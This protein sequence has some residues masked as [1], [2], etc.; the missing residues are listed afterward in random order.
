MAILSMDKDIFV[1]QT[2][3]EEKQI[4]N[5]AKFEWNSKLKRW[6]TKDLEKVKTLL[7]NENVKFTK[8]TIDYIKN[9]EIKKDQNYIKSLN[10]FSDLF[11]PVPEGLFYLQFQKAGIEYMLDK[12]YVLLADEMGL[13]KTIQSLGY[14]NCINKK[15]KILIICPLSLKENWLNEYNKWIINKN[16]FET[17]IINYDMLNKKFDELNKNWDL[18]ICDEAHYIK[19]ENA[20]R[21]KCVINL[22]EKSEKLI[23]LTGTPI[24]NRIQ[25]LFN[26]L[27]VLKHPLSDNWYKFAVK[28][29]GYTKNENGY[30]EFDESLVTDK[31]LE[32]LQ[33]T[34]RQT[35]MV[36]RM[37]SEVLAELPDKRRQL[38]KIEPDATIRKFIKEETELLKTYNVDKEELEKKMDLEYQKDINGMV[39]DYDTIPITIMSKIKKETGLLKVDY[40]IKVL[41]EMLVNEIKIVVFAWHTE[42]IERIYNEFK[43][44]SVVLTGKTPI[45][46]R[47]K[48]VEIFQNDKNCLLFLG[49]I[50]AA[51]VGI[52]LTASSN[53]VFVEFDWTP[54]ALQ[55]AEDRLHRIGQKDSVNIYHFVID[56]LID[57][58]ILQT[59]L[60]KQETI[61]KVLN[62]KKNEYIKNQIDFTKTKI[63]EIKNEKEIMIQ[64]VLVAKYSEKQ[65]KNMCD[66]I[67]YMEE[68]NFFSV[69]DKG[70]MSSFAYQI[71]QKRLLSEKQLTI[72]YQILL[73]SKNC[74]PEEIFNKIFV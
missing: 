26:I 37:K 73:K 62:D 10:K 47:Q 18:M 23:L 42:V 70:I 64:D 65:I 35:I 71:K 41:K 11:I 25:E 22:S 27:K 8:D 39:F 55:Q 43:D 50:Q 52:T 63:V 57:A 2:V 46:E 3:Y 7:K 56:G 58:K 12:K 53:V 61:D 72:A 13:G 60:K 67:V 17:T 9:I 30:Y 31:V 24:K 59:V 21:S 44:I 19:N 32:D 69:K 49:N 1:C 29:C 38:I 54:A 45:N 15:M 20:I 74:L 48:N 36:R 5:N 33:T 14:I 28:Y 4:M 68:N 34:L 40:I 51:G 66:G 6:E 16:L